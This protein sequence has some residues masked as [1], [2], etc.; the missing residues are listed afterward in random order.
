MTSSPRC[1]PIF[2]TASRSDCTAATRMAARPTI[3]V[4]AEILGSPL[5]Q[6]LPITLPVSDTKNPEIER[7]WASH[8]VERLMAQGRADGTQGQ[9]DE[10]VRLCEGYSIA[11]QYA[12]FI[13]L[14][15]DAEY[16]RWK[17]NRRN[18]L[19]LA[20]A[21]GSSNRRCRRNW[22]SSVSGPWPTWGRTRSMPIASRQPN[23]QSRR[24]NRIGRRDRPESAISIFARL[25]IRAEAAG[26]H[27][28]RSAAQSCWRWPG[29]ASRPRV[30]E[31]PRNVDGRGIPK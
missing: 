17:I 4:K 8:R 24:S 12:S 20:R 28:T 11:S 6:S 18:L 25:S 23:P 22:D 13:V 31:R 29:S 10:I 27:S 9:L 7:M 14:E 26:G 16:Q 21:T 5:E 3:Q 15:N 30:D 1:C 19:R 2:I